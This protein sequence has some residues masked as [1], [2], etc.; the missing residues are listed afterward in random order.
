MTYRGVVISGEVH[1]D[2]PDA[3]KRGGHGL[4]LSIVRRLVRQFGWAITV[5]STPDEGTAVTILFRS[6]DTRS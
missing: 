1:N 3:E 5:E 4:G 6:G 2:D